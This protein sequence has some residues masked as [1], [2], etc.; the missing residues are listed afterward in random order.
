MVQSTVHTA[1]THATLLACARN[2]ALR[3]N[4]VRLWD[5]KHKQ[6]ANWACAKDIS[7]NKRKKQ[8]N[9]NTNDKQSE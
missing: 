3:R 2:T 6:E 7:H 5:A 8:H 9:A 1:A 4:Y